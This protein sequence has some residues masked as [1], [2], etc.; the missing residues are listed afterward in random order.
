MAMH[1]T[2][3]HAAGMV[4]SQGICALVCRCNCR[5]KA[6]L[7]G[8]N[9]PPGYEPDATLL[10][11]LS[12]IERMDQTFY[13]VNPGAAPLLAF[14]NTFQT[15][16]GICA[17][18]AQCTENPAQRCCRLMV[19]LLCAHTR[20]FYKGLP[21]LPNFTNCIVNLMLLTGR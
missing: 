14:V 13:K 21:H 9:I 10:L 20:C 19:P 5:M 7:W 15:S 4:G 16:F 1:T 17:S 11:P 18:S 2:C 8:G 12:S 6:A 3:A